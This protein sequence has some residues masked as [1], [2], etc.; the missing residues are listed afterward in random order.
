MIKPQ[1]VSGKG[2]V[3]KGSLALASGV[4]VVSA[5]QAQAAEVGHSRL[6]SAP[7]QPL[8][9]TVQVNDLSPGDADTLAV[10][11]PP[12]GQWAQAGLTPPVPLQTFGARIQKGYAKG[13]R[14]IEIR[15]GQAFSSPVVDLL[16]DISS[17]SGKKRHQVSLLAQGAPDAVTPPVTTT[18][19]AANTGPEPV[20]SSIRV[21]KGDTLFGLARSNAVAGV[22]V[23]QLMVGLYQA[24][25][26]AFIQ[27]NLNLVKAGATLGVPDRASLIAIS[28]REARRIFQQHA[29]AFALYRQRLA[30]TP[31][32][33]EAGSANASSGVV[34][35]NSGSPN[36]IAAEQGG[37]R[38]RLS[39]AA[40]GA[41]SASSSGSGTSVQ[42][43]GAEQQSGS[44][45]GQSGASSSG[46]SDDA[47][48]MGKALDD[49]GNRVAQLEQNVQ[50]LNQALQ[51][52]SP[53]QGQANAASASAQQVASQAGSSAVN[54]AENAAS[55]SGNASVSG[56]ASGVSAAPGQSGASSADAGQ[57]G[58][59]AGSVSATGAAAAG[60]S[61][62]ASSQAGAA[63]VDTPS[64]GSIAGA[65]GSAATTSANS[66]VSGGSPAG[67][68]GP[69]VSA[70]GGAVGAG[71]SGN[72]SSANGKAP[73]GAA[74]VD[75]L[76][77]AVAEPVTQKAEQTVSWLQ[78]NMLGVV[79]ALLTLVVLVV[80]WLLRRGGSRSSSSESAEGAITEAMIKDKLESIDL[81]LDSS[82]NDSGNQR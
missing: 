53:G 6:V 66:S 45:G 59:P 62:A 13:S 42:G 54:S 49:A 15:S 80:A 33:A 46:A 52:Q 19:A 29:K 55:A 60:S 3:L 78:E 32:V 27:K 47:V 79:G 34:Q 40:S 63:A 36:R 41:S 39:G 9:I 12:A 14:I 30:A 71:N 58:A 70:T 4:L 25:P 81:S 7:G 51:S 16:I 18:A 67:Q 76:A 77:H 57:K 50:Q 37:D 64:A 44:A 10:S 38:L 2:G 28:D 75:Q 11:L 74:G 24:N 17:A 69:N 23:Y 72:S 20:L 26:Q 48:A 65:A 43:T 22:S 5:L 73:N 21:S 61:N 68:A 56:Q 35:V 82:A 31:N 8:V 1:R